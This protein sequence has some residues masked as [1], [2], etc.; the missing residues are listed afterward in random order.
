MPSFYL[1]STLVFLIGLFFLTALANALRK[2][3][4]KESKKELKQIG[5]VF[6][7]RPFHCLFGLTDDYEGLLFA[8]T[9]SQN[10][11]RFLTLTANA[12]WLYSLDLYSY[13]FSLVF[14]AVVLLILFFVT[15]GDYIP[16]ALGSRFPQ[17]I[18]WISII[19]SSPYLLLSL[20]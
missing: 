13:P 3:R 10:V 8:A 6:F 20:P 18:L 9:I 19:V 17:K 1:Y 7:Y 16:K 2:L 11:I 15:L 4:K 14:G 12:F 5:W